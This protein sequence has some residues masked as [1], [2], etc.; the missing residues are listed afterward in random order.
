MAEAHE[1]PEDRLDAGDIG[2]DLGLG[3]QLAL[4]VLA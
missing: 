4:F 3:K 1:S 2:R